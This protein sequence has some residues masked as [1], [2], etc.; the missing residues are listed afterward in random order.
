VFDTLRVLESDNS[1]N[2]IEFKWKESIM[3]KA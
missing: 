1:E 3:P 2:A